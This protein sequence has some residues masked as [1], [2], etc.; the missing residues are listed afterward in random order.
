MEQ[1]DESCL[2]AGP[3]SDNVEAV[4]VAA[5]RIGSAL[6]DERN[7][8]PV[9]RPGRPGFV[10]IARGQQLGLVRSHVEYIQVPAQ[11]A[12][13]AGFVLLEVETVDDDRRQCLILVLGRTGRILVHNDQCDALAVRGPVVIEHIALE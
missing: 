3:G 4:V 2:A 12:E 9:G 6:T 10:V 7:L 11:R 1:A 5:I 8:R 13:I